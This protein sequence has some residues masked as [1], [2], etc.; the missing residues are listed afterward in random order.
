MTSLP[1]P[2]PASR[3]FT[4]YLSGLAATAVGDAI[5]FVALPFVVLAGGGGQGA[6]G[7]VVLAGSLPRFLAPLLGTLA[8]RWPPRAVLGGS[9]LLRALLLGF[10]ALLALR[11]H[12]ALPALAAFA[13]L[14]GLLVTLSFTAGSAL[15]P[16]LV[17]EGALARA[18]S[19]TSAALM[20]LPLVGY[21]LG[22]LLVKLLGSG[23]TLLVGLPLYALSA[24]AALAL[25]PL[26]AS[27]AHGA[28]GFWGQLRDGLLTVRARPLLML[29]LLLG[30][31][32]NLTLNVVNV[33]A[34]LF[35]QGHAGGAGGYALFEG[36]LSGGALLGAL[37]VGPLAR[38]W[39]ADTLIAVGRGACALAVAG[40]A[41]PD[42]RAW[43]VAAGLLGVSLGLME[44]AATTR[45]QALAPRGALGRVMGVFLGLNAL[46]LSLGAALGGAHLP[47]SALFTALAALLA[48]LG[49]LWQRQSRRAP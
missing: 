10:V 15:T 43:F 49:A 39:S 35:M 9:A 23:E 21:G 3:D 38:R 33:R 48:A 7:A 12:A 16:R 27:G 25:Q 40:L 19:L 20:G 2:H 29:M 46:G 41:L 17:P 4:L 34:P 18:N 42:A 47:S 31:S 36:L 24:L 1:V 30:F 11:G 37:A 28:A 26:T 22:G 14:N 32:M 45:I 13:F 5:T 8:D 6:L 44:V